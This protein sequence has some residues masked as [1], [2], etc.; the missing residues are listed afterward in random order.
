MHRQILCA[1]NKHT[2]YKRKELCYNTSV[3][4]K[5]VWNITKNHFEDQPRTMT[6]L[7]ITYSKRILAIIAVALAR[8]IFAIELFLIYQIDINKGTLCILIAKHCLTQQT[9]L[10]KKTH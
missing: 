2:L 5:R 1:S 10:F 8:L 3:K 7:V 4:Y 9:L 6:T